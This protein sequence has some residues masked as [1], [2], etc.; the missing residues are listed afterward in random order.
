MSRKWMAGLVAALGVGTAHA[1]MSSV[2]TVFI[3]LMENHNWSSIKAS[4]SAPYINTVL[5]PMASHAEQYFNPPGLHPSLPNYIWLEAGGNFGIS[6]DLDPSAHP[7]TSTDH[8]VT[9]LTGAGVSWKTYQEDISGAACPLTAVDSYRPK[10]NPFVY[11]TDVTD[12]LNANSPTCITHVRPYSELATDLQTNN[13]ARYVFITPNLCDD[14]HDSCG[15]L[16]NSIKQG[17]T[18]LA[19][20][21]PNI[22]NSNAYRTG[23]LLLITWDEGAG[24]SDGPIGMIALSPFAKGNYQNSIHYTHSSTLKTLEEIFHVALLRDAA[25]AQTADLSDFF[26]TAINTPTA[27]ATLETPTATPSTT[28]T[29][30][31][32]AILNPTDTPAPVPPTATPTSASPT[33]TPTQTP[34]YTATATSTRTRTPKPKR[35]RRP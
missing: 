25:N 6:D 10:H 21:V 33:A 12:N 28:P 16:S 22:L 24:G 20:E 23:G 3:I 19:N 4:A 7:L 9:Q 32:T 17:D 34:T 8:L 13:V 31:A 11:F 2:N 14:M 1:Q 35:T 18:W 29:A 26:P 15:P 30:T 27:T 5:L